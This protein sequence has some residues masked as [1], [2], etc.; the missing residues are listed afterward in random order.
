MCDSGL[1]GIFEPVG[2]G[3]QQSDGLWEAHDSEQNV[4][5]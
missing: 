1:G 5:L 2:Y 4:E 3:Q